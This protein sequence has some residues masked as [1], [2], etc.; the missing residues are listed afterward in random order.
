MQLTVFM[1]FS[2]THYDRFISFILTVHTNLS[3]DSDSSYQSLEEVYNWVKY[4]EETTSDQPALNSVPE[5][6]VV[7]TFDKPSLITNN[8]LKFTLLPGISRE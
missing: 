6:E 4:Q 7:A 5:K 1:H 3:A 2:I 8:S